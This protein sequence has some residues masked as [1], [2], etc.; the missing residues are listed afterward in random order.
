MLAASCR[1]TAVWANVTRTLRIC[2]KTANLT[3]PLILHLH[4]H[5]T[6]NGIVRLILLFGFVHTLLSVEMKTGW[7]KLMMGF[8]DAHQN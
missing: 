4:I 5:M 8:S 1:C 3:P 2:L 7:L 6:S